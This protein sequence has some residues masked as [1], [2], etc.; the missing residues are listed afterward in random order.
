MDIQ[1]TN[2]N[3][4]LN[5]HDLTISFSSCFITPCKG[6]AEK[7]FNVLPV[8]LL[9]HLSVAAPPNTLQVR[10][11]LHFVVLTC[12]S[13]TMMN[14]PAAF[15]HVFRQGNNGIEPSFCTSFPNLHQPI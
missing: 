15:H 6:T 4:K 2:W 5:V 10:L 1:K 12:S 7:P 13:T 11:V 14:V 8:T 3:E 9:M